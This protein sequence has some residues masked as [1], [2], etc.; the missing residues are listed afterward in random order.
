VYGFGERTMP[1]VAGFDTFTYIEN[2]IAPRT[3]PADAV[4]SS[5]PGVRAAKP[6]G[7]PARVN[8]LRHAV[9]ASSDEDGWA[10][11][12]SVGSIITKQ[13]PDFDSRSYGY[14]ELSDF[15]AAT[16]LFDPDH[17]V[18]GDGKPA[19]PGSRPRNSGAICSCIGSPDCRA[20]LACEAGKRLPLGEPAGAGDRDKVP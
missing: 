9:E 18:P 11:L 16:S 19:Q 8:M 6:Q 12:G 17:R 4:L 15:M 10:H 2:L 13:R 7:D 20:L 5:A 14:A 1:C 3:A